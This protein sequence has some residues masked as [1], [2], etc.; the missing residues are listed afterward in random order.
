MTIQGEV[1]GGN[2]SVSQFTRTNCA[3]LYFTF[4][5]SIKVEDFSRDHPLY[6]SLAPLR[7][8]YRS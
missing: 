2:S 4:R 5:E 8:M 7:Y 1:G 3:V 6:Q